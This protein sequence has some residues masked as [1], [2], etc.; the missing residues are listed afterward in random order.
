MPWD[1]L[2]TTWTGGQYERPLSPEELAT[3]EWHDETSVA[4]NIAEI[5]QG[6]FGTR[7]ERHAGARYWVA[8][9]VDL[10]AWP[11]RRME[12]EETTRIAYNA[13]LVGKAPRAGTGA[14]D[15]ARHR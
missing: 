11:K 14:R 7:P 2:H 15:R 9:Q 12:A 6:L 3:L 5:S 13:S 1:E 4:R 10:E 8:E